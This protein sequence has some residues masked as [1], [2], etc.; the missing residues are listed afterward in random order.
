MD[1]VLF[2]EWTENDYPR[3]CRLLTNSGSGHRP[4]IAPTLYS[5]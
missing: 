4:V 5:T 3:V 1:P 2:L